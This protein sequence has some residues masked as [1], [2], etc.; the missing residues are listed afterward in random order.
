MVVLFIVEERE[1]SRELPLKP[2]T[3]PPINLRPAASWEELN[4]EIGV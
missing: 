2:F 1:R 4:E 3:A